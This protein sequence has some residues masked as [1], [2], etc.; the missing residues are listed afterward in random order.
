MIV[1]KPT[2][3]FHTSQVFF[4]FLALCCFCSCAAFQ[5][6]WK[7]GPCMFQI[8]RYTPFTTHRLHSWSLRIFHF[9]F[10][11]RHILLA[12][13]ALDTGHLREI[14]QRRAT[15]TSTQRN[16]RRFHP[17]RHRRG[18][19]PPHLVSGQFWRLS[20]EVNSWCRFI[21]TISAWTQPGCKNA[22]NDPHASLGDDFKRG[23]DGFCNTKKAGAI[24]FWFLF[25][26]WHHYVIYHLSN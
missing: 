5:A 15:C 6:K 18:G 26:K 22:D 9:P 20:F 10:P 8:S 13:H 14:R 17:D 3:I 19:Q 16:S 1:S 7:I 2:I 25:S 23:L 4:N 24:F 21:T 12:L 11:C